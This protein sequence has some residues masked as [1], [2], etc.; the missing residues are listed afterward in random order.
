MRQT[1]HVVRETRGAVDGLSDLLREFRGRFSKRGLHGL[2]SQH[3]QGQSL[4]DV[5]M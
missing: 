2:K 5:V 4:I 3:Q 1:L